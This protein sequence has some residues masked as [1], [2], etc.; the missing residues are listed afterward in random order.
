MALS[1][2]NTRT[3]HRGVEFDLSN[4]INTQNSLRQR[5]NTRRPTRSATILAPDAKVP[6]NGLPN[7]LNL[8]GK[9][10]KRAAP[11]TYRQLKRKMTMPSVTTLE[12]TSSKWLSGFNLDVGRNSHFYTETLTDEQLEYL[13]G[14][15]YRA[16][17][18]LSYLVP[19]VS[20]VLRYTVTGN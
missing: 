10:F 13:G 16:L 11:T 9:V 18:V 2:I 5:R 1:P 7:P 14:A 17:R 3:S 20:G 8:V 15:E 4:T 6:E 12:A 19:A